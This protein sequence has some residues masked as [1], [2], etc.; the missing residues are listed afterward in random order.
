MKSLGF[1]E[2]FQ[3]EGGILKYL[4]VVPP[5]EQRWEGECFVFDGRVSVDVRLRKGTAPDLSQAENE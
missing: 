4:E 1:K 3:L 5:E 2:V